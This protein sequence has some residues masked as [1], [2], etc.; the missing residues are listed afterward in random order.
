MQSQQRAGI[1]MYGWLVNH[2][3][4]AMFPA[5][6]YDF[7]QVQFP[8]IKRTNKGNRISVLANAA[9]DGMHGFGE[10]FGTEDETLNQI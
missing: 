2:S 7:S 6:N 3:L 4:I 10:W 9:N 8:H 1:N 5:T